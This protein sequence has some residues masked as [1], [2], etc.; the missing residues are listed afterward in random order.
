[1]L[2]LALQQSERL[3]IA[4]GNFVELLK[5]SFANNKSFE[6]RISD[7]EQGLNLSRLKKYFT[8]VLV[9]NV[10]R[11]NIISEKF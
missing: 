2:E 10:P 11:L 6:T 4:I 1:M 8:T 5:R 7:I 3:I 9:F